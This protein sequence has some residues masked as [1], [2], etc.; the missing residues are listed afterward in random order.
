MAGYANRQSGEVESL[1][2]L[3]VRLPPRLLERFRGPT[4]K[5]PG[6]RPGE[7]GSIPS[8]ITGFVCWSVGVSAARRRGKAEDPVQ[9]R[10]GPLGTLWACMTLAAADPCKIGAMGS[11]PIRSTRTIRAAGPTGRRR[12][13]KPEIGVRLSGGPLAIFMGSSSNGK[14]S[15]RQTENPGSIPG[16]STRSNGR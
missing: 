4:A 6:R 13:R 1:V 14:T 16:G 5:T 3:R 10:D 12:L 9:F 15:V 11:T 7:G 8:G 2:N